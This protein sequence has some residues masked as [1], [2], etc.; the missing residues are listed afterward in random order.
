MKGSDEGPAGMVLIQC[1]DLSP[2]RGQDARRSPTGGQY[3][4]VVHYLRNSTKRKKIHFKK[5]F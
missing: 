4:N 5:S 2:E 1:D 3:T